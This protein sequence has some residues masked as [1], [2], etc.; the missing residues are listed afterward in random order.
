MLQYDGDYDIYYLEEPAGI[1]LKVTSNN[2]Q[3][4]YPCLQLD[5]AGNA[6]IA[7]KGHDGHDYEEYYVHNV[8]GAFCEPIQVSFTSTDVGVFVPERSCLAIDS[9]GLAYCL[10]VRV[11]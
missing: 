11:L 3:D 6:H 2:T 7:F 8:G 4:L 9:L 1:P 5:L 10:Q